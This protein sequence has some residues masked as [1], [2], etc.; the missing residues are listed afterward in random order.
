MKLLHNHPVD[1]FADK[2]VDGCGRLASPTQTLGL[3]PIHPPFI[4]DLCTGKDRNLINKNMDLQDY[5]CFPQAY[6]STT[7]Y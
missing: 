2:L 7:I 1:N 4:T 6:T 3:S 5:S